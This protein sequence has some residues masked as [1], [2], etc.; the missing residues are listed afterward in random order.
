MKSWTAGSSN[1]G[2][3]SERDSLSGHGASL[4]VGVV[5]PLLYGLHQDG[6]VPETRKRRTTITVCSLRRWDAGGRRE[7]EE[8]LLL[9]HRSE[10]ESSLGAGDPARVSPRWQQRQPGGK[11]MRQT[12]NLPP[13]E[14]ALHLG[15]CH[16]TRRV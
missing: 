12:Q 13:A 15:R 10:P 16:M 14:A 5:D 7:E 8:E 3:R 2:V 4:C 1:L 11:L 6:P 9:V